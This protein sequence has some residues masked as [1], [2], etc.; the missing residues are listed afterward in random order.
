MYNVY[1]YGSL[2]NESVRTDAYAKALRQTIRQDSV[3]LDIGTGT[4]IFT[5]LA[6]QFGARRVYAVESDDVI[7]I[8]REIAAV[9]GY[10]ERIE[11]IQSMSTRI[12]LPEP[13][14]VIVSDLRGS[15]P[16]YKQSLISIIDARRRFLASGGRLIPQVDTLWV[17]VVEASELYQNFKSPW[18][19]N[20]FGLDMRPALRYATNTL[21]QGRA[22]PEKLLV[23]PKCWATLD[24]YN[25]KSPDVNGNV[26][27]TAKRS[28]TAHGLSVWFNTNLAED[29]GFSNA[30]SEPELLYSNTFFPWTEPVELAIGDQVSV[31]LEVNLVG[32]SYV[33][34]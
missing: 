26:I 15:L 23:R 31:T 27:W 3:V 17:A 12:T 9:N 18:D 14:D 25:L 32:D 33:K 30:P 22:K 24:Y 13:V 1:D 6:C 8:A 28:G 29:V 10:S 5:L 4:G 16:M 11:F 20:I 34:R 19:D 21:R 2:I 7:Q